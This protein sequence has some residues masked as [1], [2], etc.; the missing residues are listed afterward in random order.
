MRRIDK[1]QG[2]FLLAMEPQERALIRQLL[3]ELRELLALS[4]DDPR[5]RRLYPSAHEQDVELENEY[6]SLTRDE[7]QNGRLASI[8][9]VEASVDAELLDVDQLTAW[10][11]AVNALRLVLGTMLDITDD[12][13]ELSFNPEDPNA[14]TVALYGYLGGLLDEIVD[15]QLS[16]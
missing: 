13:D 9:A 4:P 7:L 6:R 5:V 3:D 16:D 15:A 11:Q 12:D 2:K 8:D 10:M 14:R 1:R